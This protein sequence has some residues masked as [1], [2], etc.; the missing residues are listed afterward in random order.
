MKIVGIVKLYTLEVVVIHVLENMQGERA[1]VTSFAGFKRLLPF[2]VIAMRF[3]DARIIHRLPLVTVAA[4]W[5]GAMQ[6]LIE[7]MGAVY[8]DPASNRL[9]VVDLEGKVLHGPASTKTLGIV[10]RTSGITI[11]GTLLGQRM[12]SPSVGWVVHL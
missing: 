5:T 10:T 8:P 6:V 1:V 2:D 3:E 9:G 11:L 12:L 4:G 7:S